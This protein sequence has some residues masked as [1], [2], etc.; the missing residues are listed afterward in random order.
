LLQVRQEKASDDFSKEIHST[1]DAT[2]EMSEGRFAT[3]DR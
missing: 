3:S 2:T 1:P